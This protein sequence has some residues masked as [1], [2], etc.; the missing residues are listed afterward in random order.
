MIDSGLI[1]RVKH[2]MPKDW[3]MPFEIDF[4][5]ENAVIE[6]PISHF[7]HAGGNR[8]TGEIVAVRKRI[9]LNSGYAVGEY[10][11]S[12]FRTECER[13]TSDANNTSRHQNTGQTGAFMECTIPNSGDTLADLKTDHVSATRKRLFPNTGDMIA[14]G[15]TGYVGPVDKQI[16]ADHGDRQA[17]D[18]VRD[19]HFAT[20]TNVTGEGN[21]TVIGQVIEI[22]WFGHVSSSCL[23]CGN[24]SENWSRG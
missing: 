23:N 12:E 14:D 2:A 3:R 13:R 4:F 24:I 15:E 20:G 5:Q 9:R 10:K 17:L 8:D 6:S 1:V 7:D 22:L 11:G 21:F 19:D 16:T 18:C